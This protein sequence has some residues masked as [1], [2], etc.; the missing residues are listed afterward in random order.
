MNVTFFWFQTTIKCNESVQFPTNNWKSSKC[1]F[2]STGT[3]DRLLIFRA[4]SILS[5]H[6]EDVGIPT[7]LILETRV[8]VHF[9]SVPFC[10]SCFFLHVMCY[11]YWTDNTLLWVKSWLLVNSY[12]LRVHYTT[13]NDL[14]VDLE[15]I[16]KKNSKTLLQEKKIQKAFLW[17]K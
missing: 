13:M 17:K 16:K 7:K 10:K 11:S 14:R 9:S 6:W 15:E 12:D 4:W 3:N 1:I 5:R 8:E 2:K